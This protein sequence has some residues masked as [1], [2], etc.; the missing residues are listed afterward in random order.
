[1]IKITENVEK[2]NE[3]NNYP[4]YD[5]S[6]K[7]VILINRCLDGLINLS[8]DKLEDSG[9]SDE[10]IAALL[11]FKEIL[12]IVISDYALDPSNGNKPIMYITNKFY[13]E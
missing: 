11:N 9:V 13:N 4:L 8:Y 10:S 3:E 1:M 2:N 6:R 5:F 7:S 12:S